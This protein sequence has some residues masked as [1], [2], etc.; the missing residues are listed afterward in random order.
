MCSFACYHDLVFGAARSNWS[1]LFAG[2][3][4]RSLDARYE[5]RGERAGAI[6]EPVR[7]AGDISWALVPSGPIARQF[8]HGT[9]LH[10]SVASVGSA[11]ARS[12]FPAP[13]TIA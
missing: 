13:R 8:G 11:F 12:R 9:W 3:S 2:G 4:A 6:A 10:Q 1:A 7:S 5:R